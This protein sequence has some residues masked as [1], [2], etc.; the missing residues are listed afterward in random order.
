MEKT[1][2]HP[3]ALTAEVPRRARPAVKG[4]ILASVFA[5]A[6]GIIGWIIVRSGGR[7]EL[8]TWIAHSIWQSSG[9]DRFLAGIMIGLTILG[10]WMGMGAIHLAGAI[11]QFARRRWQLGLAW[12]LIAASGA[13]LNQ[14][15]KLAFDRPRPPVE[16][17]DPVVTE[18]NQSFPSGH[19]MGA[20]IGFGVVAYMLCLETRR[21]DARALLVVGFGVI[22]LGVGASRVYLRAHWFSDVIAGFLAGAAWLSMCLGIT[23][24]LRRR[25]AC[26]ASNGPG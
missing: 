21:W 5:L 9:D 19:A 16:W 6:F 17:R 11:W 10:S 13:G 20:V 26:G 15:L 18:T 24:T 1:E 12:V 3:E 25:Q 22:A 14:V 8:D 2:N 23:E 7:V 4:L